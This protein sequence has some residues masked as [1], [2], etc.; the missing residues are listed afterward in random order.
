MKTITLNTRITFTATGEKYYILEQT[1]SGFQFKPIKFEKGLPTVPRTFEEIKDE[2]LSNQID[3]DGFEHS[4]ADN[5][6]VSLIMEAYI[7]DSLINGY[8]DSLSTITIEKDGIIERQEKAI[9]EQ[10]RTI[11]QQKNA[12]Q[13]Y[14][15]EI[16]NLST[17]F[18]NQKEQW[19]EDEKEYKK[20]IEGFEATIEEPT[21]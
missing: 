13:G 12:I 11:Q 15:D 19:L 1:E 9:T 21:K 3:I 4:E 14:N 7:K 17:I 18:N 6:L 8:K 5:V 16:A 20:V 2:F 10:Q